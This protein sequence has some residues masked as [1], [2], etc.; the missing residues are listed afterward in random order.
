MLALGSH[1]LTSGY[2]SLPTLKLHLVQ[3]LIT[4]C[5]STGHH[6]CG[7][8]FVSVA[9]ATV[10]Q[11]CEHKL[12]GR[13]LPTEANCKS[14]EEGENASRRNTRTALKEFGCVFTPLR[15]CFFAGSW[16]EQYE[17]QWIELLSV[18][19]EL[20][21]WVSIFVC[22]SEHIVFDEAFAGEVGVSTR[23]TRPKQTGLIFLD[24]L[25][26]LAV[27]EALG[28]VALSLTTSFLLWPGF[29]TLDFTNIHI[30]AK[31]IL[32][33]PLYTHAQTQTL[34]LRLL[35]QT[36]ELWARAPWGAVHHG[37]QQN[38]WHS[39]HVQSMYC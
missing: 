36:S 16:S 30:S 12:K 23:T 20:S 10:R 28:L 39:Q 27:K 2:V 7:L 14:E 5:R 32:P 6:L 21:G 25:K 19:H 15:S 1:I 31:G 17:D 26:S 37:S 4:P 33:K 24:L 22:T 38:S 18:F 35:K 11:A 8:V 3:H 34:Q 9:V 29:Q 13:L